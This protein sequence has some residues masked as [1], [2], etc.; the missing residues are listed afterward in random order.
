MK[1]WSNLAKIVMRRTYARKDN[2]LT[3]ELGNPD[4]HG[5]R[6]YPLE[7]W[8]QIIE[9][10]VMGNVK[11]RNVSETEIKELLR[12]GKERKAIPAGRGLW[13]SG[14]VA[15]SRIGGV[16]L[17]NCWFATASHWNNFVIVADLLMLGGGV[18]ASV[19]HKFVSKLPKVKKGVVIT[20]QPGYGA[21]FIVPDTREGWCELMYRVFESYFVTGKSFTYSTSVL[22]GAGQPIKGFGGIS[23]GPIPLIHFV[24]N[25]NNILGSRAGR[26]IRP[27]DAADII[28]SIGEVVV[29]GNV[30][31]SA[32]LL[33]GDCWDKEFLTAKRWDLGQIPAHRSNANYSVTCDDADDLHPLYWKTFEAGEAFGLVN[34]KAIQKYGRMGELKR[35]TAEGVNPCGE[36]TLEPFEPCNLQEIILPHISNVEEFISAAVL[37]HRYG[38]RVTL[39][40]YHHPEIQEVIER[41]RRVGTSITGCLSSPL[42]TAENLDRAYAAIQAENIRY[43]KELGIPPSIRTTTNK[44][45]GTVSKVADMD[46]YEGIHGA[47]SRYIIQ[48]VRF[49]SND[50]LIPVLKAAGHFMEPVRKLDGT[51]DYGTQVVDFYVKAPDGAPVTDEGFDTWKQLKVWDVAQ[52]HWSDQ[53]VSVSVYY[54]REE[55]PEIKEWVSNNIKNLKTI[56]FMAH[57]EHGY[58][59]APKESISKSKFEELSSKIKPI[60]FDDIQGE[61]LES[62]ECSDGFCP[63]K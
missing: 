41:N 48:R 6:Y 12:L 37:M 57:S 54:R 51:V 33:L 22:R 14:T 28:T 55:I 27:I 8:D 30:R 35:D 53:S 11:G 49:A 20:H 46:G 39:E 52:K 61:G 13:F 50:P 63:V 1:E 36:A 38:K 24:D 4:V 34:R 32:I 23:S 44:P 18:G 31:R 5:D 29:S 56:S 60:N 62:Q 16:A 59:Q 7:N 26:H 45:S 9:R 43:S 47:W 2:P 42:F 15:H 58:L 21:G 25:I 3:G 10:Q 19:E 40:K 17:N